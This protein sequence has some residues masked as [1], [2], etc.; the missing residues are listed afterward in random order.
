M[1]RQNV[2]NN[3]YYKWRYPSSWWKNIRMFFRSFKYAWQRITRGYA[4]CDTFDL[5]TY[6]LD[7]LA[8]TLYHL[9]DNHW[10]YPGD[11]QFPND[12]LWTAYL[13]EMAGCFYRANECNDYYLTPE[14]DKWFTWC[15]KI[16]EGISH[17]DNPHTKDMVVEEQMLHNKRN[18][19]LRTGL[20]MLY[21]VWW[22]LWD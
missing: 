13:K 18:E 2:F 20:E 1:K 12:E 22:H 3:P 4:D 15:D 19:D 8:G 21:K 6:Y 9:A 7:T 11:E 5:D 16:P 10:G 17:M 14:A